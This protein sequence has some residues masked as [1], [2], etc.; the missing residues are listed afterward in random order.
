MSSDVWAARGTRSLRWSLPA[1]V[2]SGMLIYDPPPSLTGI[3]VVAGQPYTFACQVRGGG[4]DPNVTVTP[5]LSWLAADGWVQSSDIGAPTVLADVPV[6]VSVT[7]LVPPAGAVW[8][9]AELRVD[10]ATV[11]AASSAIGQFAELSPAWVTSQGLRAAESILTDWMFGQTSDVYVD[12]AQL[13]MSATL[14]PWMPGEGV[15]LVSITDM[16]ETVPVFGNRDLS[17][18]LVEVG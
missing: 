3:P 18:T 13:A 5:A 2:T 1:R 9:R 10:P 15:P 7:R 16:P 11:D 8:L 12:A 17:I 6:Q 4:A 14:D